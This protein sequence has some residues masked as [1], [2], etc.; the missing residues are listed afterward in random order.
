MALVGFEG[1]IRLEVDKIFL[2]IYLF[3]Y[4]AREKQIDVQVL[5]LERMQFE[6]KCLKRVHVLHIDCECFTG[7]K[8]I[9]FILFCLFFLLFSLDCH[10]RL[11][12][13]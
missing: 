7:K 4:L 9:F 3:I 1:Q 5:F 11:R 6:L 2:F 12:D 13:L 8:V 10:A